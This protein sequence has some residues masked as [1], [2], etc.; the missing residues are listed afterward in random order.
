MKQKFS[1]TEAEEKITEFFS[2]IKRK[3]PE[4]VK[5]IKKLA[6]SKN[7]KLGDKRKL[8]CKKCLSP[9][10]N[11]S[12]KINDGFITINC[13]NCSYKNRWK[14]KKEIDFGLHSHDDGCC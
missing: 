1:K 10:G 12:I 4:D 9:H 7:I 6:M 5:K 8:F 13:G 3:T 11:S 14:L 2:D